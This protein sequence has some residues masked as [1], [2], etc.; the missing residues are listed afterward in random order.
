MSVT[1]EHE[2]ITLHHGRTA[3]ALHRRKTASGPNLLLLHELYASSE[4]W[5]AEVDDWQGSV[6]ALDFSGHGSSAWR[7]GGVYFP[8]ILAADA[9][10]ALAEIGSVCLAGTGVGAYA[11]LLLAGGRSESVS[12][13]LLLSGAG[14]EGCGAEPPV[15]PAPGSFARLVAANRAST[16]PASA[17]SD[18]RVVL[19]AA[20][21]RPPD[22]ARSFAEHAGTI[23]LAEDGTHRPPW[24]EEVRGAD[25]VSTTATD[26]GLALTSLHAAAAPG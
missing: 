24:W 13:S 25:G 26:L 16:D 3:L 11:A 17:T 18:P 23:L 5:G 20:D 19:A 15:D 1:T 4:I 14:L 12:A 7:E 8:E 9:D 10:A 6:W 2:R 21:A 22:Y